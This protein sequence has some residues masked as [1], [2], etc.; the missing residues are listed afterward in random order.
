MRSLAV[1]QRLWVSVPGAGYVGVGGVAGPAV[2][3]VDAELVVNGQRTRVSELPLEGSYTHL[4]HEGDDAE[5]IVP[6]TWHATL[7]LEQ[8]VYTKGMY[9]NQNII[10]RLSNAFTLAQL[11][12]SPLGRGLA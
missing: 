8:A 1:G 11:A 2:P 3:M 9:A 12:D 6:M 4:Q 10:T 5:W 7:P